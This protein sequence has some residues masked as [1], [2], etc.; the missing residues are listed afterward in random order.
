MFFLLNIIL[1]FF[2]HIFSLNI[3]M[4]TRL[5]FFFFTLLISKH[6]YQG[7]K[8]TIN[9]PHSY[10]A[11]IFLVRKKN[12][13]TNR[14]SWMPNIILFILPCCHPL[15][16]VMA[17]RFNI[18]GMKVMLLAHWNKAFTQVV[19]IKIYVV[20][21]FLSCLSQQVTAKLSAERVSRL[22]LTWRL[23]EEKIEIFVQKVG[24][25]G[26]QPDKRVQLK[27]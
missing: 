27:T 20:I 11:Q 13:D 22:W 15:Y 23:L 21:M 19:I 5:F 6:P 16:H 8:N 14:A 17:I 2:I 12:K 4:T 9:S 26:R 25:N 18:L 3:L 24:N 10:F 7:H 1:I